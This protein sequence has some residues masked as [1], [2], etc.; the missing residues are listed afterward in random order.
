MTDMLSGAIDELY[1]RAKTADERPARGGGDFGDL[2]WFKPAAGKEKNTY[3]YTGFMMTY[4]P[5]STGR[6]S[7]FRTRFQHF[8]LPKNAQDTVIRTCMRLSEPHLNITCPFCE[9]V[10]AEIEMSRSTDEQKALREFE[11]RGYSYVNLLPLTELGRQVQYSN[12]EGA[13]GKTPYLPH[14]LRMGDKHADKIAQ[15]L[16]D[17]DV[18]SN[19]LLNPLNPQSACNLIINVERK[20]SRAMDVRYAYTFGMARRAWADSQ[21]WIDYLYANTYDLA[22][23]FRGC[24]EDEYKQQWEE[25]TEV[26]AELARRRANRVTTSGFDAPGFKAGPATPAF[27]PPAGFS[28]AP[29][30]APAAAP[31][32]SV[33]PPS[34]QQAA[35]PPSFAPLQQQAAP[36]SFA[37]PQAT[38][39]EA[40]NVQPMTAPVSP[41]TTGTTVASP[42]TPAS[43]APSTPSSFAPPSFAPPSFG[44]GGGFQQG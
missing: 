44:S 12:N 21:E 16:R 1:Q 32:T 23:I 8:G 28:A 4:V 26:K 25:M 7:L 9:L 36:P 22:K 37:P 38:F 35:A 3:V 24:N 27:A 42:V 34:M 33:F 2:R 5:E 11:A 39:T 41:S 30:F 15:F 17:N 19:P 40:P 10:N 14:I 6:A 20:G 13:D 18:L 29:S 31:T 43:A